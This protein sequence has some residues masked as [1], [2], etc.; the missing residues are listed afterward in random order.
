MCHRDPAKLIPSVASVV[1]ST[2]RGL[3]GGDA[4]TSADIGAF[5]LEHLQV[6]IDRVMQFRREHGDAQF[7]DMPHKAFNADP[8]GTLAQIYDWLGVELS[9]RAL[10]EMEAWLGRNRAGRAWRIQLYR[11]E[12][13]PR[14]GFDPYCVWPLYEQFGL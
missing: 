5:V 13:W 2:H 6:S 8:F 14:P 11:R 3:L 1:R 9:P 12:V 4:A 10:T 7:F